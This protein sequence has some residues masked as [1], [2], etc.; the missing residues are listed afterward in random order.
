[1][2]YVHAC[3]KLV[4]TL[5]IAVCSAGILEM[6]RRVDKDISKYAVSELWRRW[7]IWSLINLGCYLG[8]IFRRGNEGII[9]LGIFAM[10][11]VVCAVLDGLCYQVNDFLQFIGLLGA[12]IWVSTKQL[13]VGIGVDL[14]LFVMIQY[15]LF[16]SMYGKA[17]VMGF[18]IC[19]VF[20]AGAGM[21][22][23]HFLYYMA[24][25]FALLGVVQIYNKNVTK[26]GK[27]K[28]PVA[29]FPYISCGFWIF[30][31]RYVR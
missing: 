22:L 25:C 5:M 14:I 13:R 10:Y 20:L 7:R 18:S 1:M 19:A 11:L 27:L 3:V 15:K 4:I 6:L 31:S 12:I 29:L 17:D 28:E 26:Q 21:G 8:D 30:W 2:N 24:L 16:L 23:E 9:G